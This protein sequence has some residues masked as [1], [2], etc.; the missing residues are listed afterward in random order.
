[1]SKKKDNIIERKAKKIVILFIV[2]LLV[3]IFVVYFFM[4]LFAPTYA[5]GV[6]INYYVTLAGIFPVLLIALFLTSTEKSQK[7]AGSGWRSLLSEGKTEGLV[8]FAV[9]EIACL[10]AIAMDR[11][12]TL[13]L[14]ATIFGVVAMITVTYHRIV[15]GNTD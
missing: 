11:S 2:L 3:L 5:A 12:L 1:M 9:G 7:R 4:K 10:L 14:V 13:F 6:S 8:G 15:Y